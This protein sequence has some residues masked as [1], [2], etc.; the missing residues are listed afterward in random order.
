M[1]LRKLLL[2]SVIALLAAFVMSTEALA[3]ESQKNLNIPNVLQAQSNWCWAANSLAIL[4][5]YNIYTGQCTFVSYVKTGTTTP[6]TCDN[7][8]GWRW[9]SQ[10]GLDYFGVSSTQYTGTFSFTTVKSEINNNRPIYA[11][12]AWLGTGDTVTGRHVQT[13]DGYYEN[14]NLIITDVSYME[15]LQGQ[16]YSMDYNDFVYVA[17]PSGRKWEAGLYNF[18]RKP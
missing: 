12:I 4:N 13:I 10:S 2:S 8:G 7:L 6:E 16:H 14:T 9:E 18:A 5:Y 1:K 11:E 3:I 17:G 15:S